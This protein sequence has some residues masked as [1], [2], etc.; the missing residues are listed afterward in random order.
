MKKPQHTP[1]PWRALPDGHVAIDE[2]AAADLQH[3]SGLVAYLHD[4]ESAKPGGGTRLMQQIISDMKK[5]GVET[6]ALQPIG[7]ARKGGSFE[8][9]EYGDPGHDRLVR[10]YERFGFKIR[11][12]EHPY[13]NP[14]M[15]LRLK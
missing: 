11:P 5:R 2:G 13:N 3:E 8:F 1:G 12:T 14:V 6:F 4:I 10:F 9:T 7:Y 15:Y